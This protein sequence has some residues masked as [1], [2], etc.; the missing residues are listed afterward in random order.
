MSEEDLSSMANENRWYFAIL[1]HKSLANISLYKIVPQ[2]EIRFL[3][4]EL[5]PQ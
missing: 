3:I 1:E 4:R 5:S 2:Y